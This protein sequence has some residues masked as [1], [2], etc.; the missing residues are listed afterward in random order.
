M[1]ELCL[2]KSI[3]F[4]SASDQEAG[5]SQFIYQLRRALPRAAM[6]PVDVTIGEC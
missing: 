1:S 2:Q 3:R 4:P 6:T 5:I